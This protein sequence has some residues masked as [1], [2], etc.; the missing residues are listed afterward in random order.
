MDKIELVVIVCARGEW[1]FELVSSRPIES[2]KK[3]GRNKNRRV[4]NVHSSAGRVPVP[5]VVTQMSAKV[6]RD[7]ENIPPPSLD[8]F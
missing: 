1:A 5:T 7:Q 8:Y 2:K 4:C 3:I 6:H